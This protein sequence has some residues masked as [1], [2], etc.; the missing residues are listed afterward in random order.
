MAVSTAV[1]SGVGARHPRATLAVVASGTLLMIMAFTLPLATIVPTAASLDAD[2]AGRTWILS[3]MSIGLAAALLTAGAVADDLGRRRTFVIGLVV[4][5]VGGLVCAVVSDPL[6]FV[7]ARV[8]QGVGGAAVTAASLG[9]LAHAF[10][11][12]PARVAASGT[13]GAALGAGI[14][15]GP[16]V[17]GLCDVWVSWRLAYAVL[18]VAA[19]ATVVLALRYLDESRAPRRRRLDRWG[20]LLIA[21]GLS[22]LLAGLVESREPDRGALATGLFVAAGVLLVGFVVAERRGRAPMLDL[23]LLRHRPFVAASVA[24][25]A[26]GMGVIALF[27]FMAIFLDTGFGIGALGAGVLLLSWSATSVAASLLARRLP[28]RWSGRAQL[29]AGLLGVSI[30]Q[31]L[32]AGVGPGTSWWRFVPAL[33]LAGIASGVLNAAL[34]REAV[35]SVPAGREAMG[36]GANNTARYVGSAIGVTVVAVVVDAH[37]PTQQDLY[38]GWNVAAL[39]TAAFSLVGALVVVACRTRPAP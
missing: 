25:F 33:V 18:A 26:T 20:G 5:A 24:A 13:W 32:L 19:V 34:G 14:A 37:G 6:S 21:G 28:A 15:I 3:S 10:A 39:V 7:L 29:A 38:D 4:L 2:T 8:V 17:A 22:C 9:I 11:P 16:V 23:A 31:A 12:G 1:V 30:G 36:S 35:A 27:S